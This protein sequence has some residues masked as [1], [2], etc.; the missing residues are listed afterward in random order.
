M[1]GT[2][3]AW[4]YV[5][6][7]EHAVCWVA[8]GV[9]LERGELAGWRLWGIRSGQSGLALVGVVLVLFL[10]ISIVVLGPSEI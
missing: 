8:E 1:G 4:G 9:V 5:A 3:R 6:W 7:P 2:R 10:D